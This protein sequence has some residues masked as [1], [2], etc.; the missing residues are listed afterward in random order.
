MT[1]ALRNAE[2]KKKILA[3]RSQL[4]GGG[5]QDVR[6]N[7]DLDAGNG[8]RNSRRS[9]GLRTKKRDQRDQRQHPF[10]SCRDP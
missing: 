2:M 7:A 1:N 8:V 4:D 6:G 5:M 10:L 9:F 3:E